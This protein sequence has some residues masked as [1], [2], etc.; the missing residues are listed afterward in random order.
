MRVYF[1]SRRA[2]PQSRVY[3]AASLLLILTHIY[4][5]I[6]IVINGYALGVNAV[7]IYR[8]LKQRGAMENRAA[9]CGSIYAKPQTDCGKRGFINTNSTKINFCES[10]IYIY[11]VLSCAAL[12]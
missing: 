10:I 11:P 8:R 4:L 7:Q 6:H 1:H 9:G 3:G 12:N 5:F 2:I